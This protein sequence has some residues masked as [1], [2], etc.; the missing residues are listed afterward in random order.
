MPPRKHEMCNTTQI[1]FFSLIFSDRSSYKFI[2]IGVSIGIGVLIS[3]VVGLVIL[4]VLIRRNSRKENTK[5]D[6]GM[7]WIIENNLLYSAARRYV[8]NPL[9]VF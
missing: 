3:V 4:W 5:G 8:R 6:Y 2:V 1:P 9:N 7:R